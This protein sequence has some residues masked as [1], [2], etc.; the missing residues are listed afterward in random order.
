[1]VF[2]IRMIQFIDCAVT[3]YLLYQYVRLIFNRQNKNRRWIF[4][5]VVT[6]ILTMELLLSYKYA[7]GYDDLINRELHPYFYRPYQMIALQFI[8]YALSVIQMK[9]RKP[10]NRKVNYF[11]ATHM[12]FLLAGGVFLTHS[13]NSYLPE[14]DSDIWYTGSVMLYLFYLISQ[15]M[16]YVTIY[17]F[18]DKIEENMQKQLVII[19]KNKEMSH[20]RQIAEMNERHRELIHN[21]SH[22]LKVI[23][24]LARE[25]RTEEIAAILSEL[26]VSLEKSE[27]RIYSSHIVLNSLLSEKA[28]EAE[29][30]K[31]SFDAYV[32]PGSHFGMVT[33]TELISMLGN[34]LDN[35]ICAASQA[36]TQMNETRAEESSGK[37]KEERAAVVLRIFMQNES[38]FCITKISNDYI[39]KLLLENGAYRTT[40]EEDGIHGIGIKSVEK[41]AEE[42]GGY[43][44]CYTKENKFYSILVLPAQ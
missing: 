16:L 28:A 38:N 20:L 34:L 15:M 7:A 14:T 29:R 12:I 2:F 25:D 31:I 9:R 8:L 13:Y 40:K 5:L 44:E 1:M 36:Q 37:R 41:A 21:T 23:G 11:F 32:E 39:G 19:Q 17:L 4:T 22:Y 24:E 33:E 43:L 30:K 35:A 18:S 6:A 27:T 26:N 42:N 10:E 3:I